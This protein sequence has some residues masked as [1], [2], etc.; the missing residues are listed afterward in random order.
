MVIVGDWLIES[1]SPQISSTLLSILIDANILILSWIS[2]QSKPRST[3]IYIYFFF[4]FIYKCL[5]L[6]SELVNVG[7]NFITRLVS[8]IG[9]MH[10]VSSALA[11]T[12]LASWLLKEHKIMVGDEADVIVE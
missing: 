9:L 1:K 12:P 11:S 2:N 4:N 7:Q 3:F 10:M 8:P 5:L 6:N